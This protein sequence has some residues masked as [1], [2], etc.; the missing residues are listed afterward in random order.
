[1]KG[2]DRWGAGLGHGTGVKPEMWVRAVANGAT[3][4]DVAAPVGWGQKAKSLAW[5]LVAIV[6][7]S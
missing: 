6:L 2:S 1:M 7:K 5:E 3:W 4:G